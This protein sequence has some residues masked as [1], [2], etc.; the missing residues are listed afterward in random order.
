MV[1]DWIGVALA[2]FIG[3]LPIANPFSTAVVFL[4]ITEGLSEERRRH[5][6]RMAC[7]YMA[8]V[9]IVFLLAG[10]LIMAFFGISIPGLRI[11]G[12]LIVVRIG[13]GM[14]DPT[15]DQEMSEDL[16]DDA[17]QKAD[18]AFTP[19]AM[20]MLSGPGSIAVTIGMAAESRGVGEAMAIIAGIGLVA[21]VSYVVLR[22]SDRVVGFMGASGMN[23]MGRVMGFLLVCVGIQF[24]V[25]GTHNILTS[26][27]F[28]DP[29]L[30]MLRH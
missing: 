15:P 1:V 28:V 20:P 11:A 24:I 25:D 7:I 2:T 30:E 6:A 29:I 14:L 21:F 18:V 26:A 22:A 23:A 4:T 13:F 5:Q 19:L 8:A 10:T 27:A 3:I 12:G 17:V 16:R 9:L